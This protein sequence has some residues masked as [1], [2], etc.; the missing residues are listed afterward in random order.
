MSNTITK[1]LNSI[2]IQFL[3]LEQQLKTYREL[4]SISPLD[5]LSVV[6]RRERKK[7]KLTL[8]SLSELSGVSYSTLVKMESG[9]DGINLKTLKQLVQTLGIKLWVG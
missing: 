4:E 6:I 7:Q 5:E 2:Q 9:D 1:E 8:R 3:N